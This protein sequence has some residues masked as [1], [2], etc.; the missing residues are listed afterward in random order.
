MLS[1]IILSLVL[2]IV[3]GSVLAPPRNVRI[4][5]GVD[6]LQGDF[7]F[8]VSIHLATRELSS[9]G[10]G[11]ICTGTLISSWAVLTSARCVQNGSGVRVPEEL[12]L[13]VGTKSSTNCSGAV[14]LSVE[15]IRTHEGA[16]LAILRLKWAVTNVE[17]AVLNEYQQDLGKQCIL[18]G[19]GANGTQSG[20]VERL[21]E[22]YVRVVAC[23]DG[24]VCAVSEREHAGAC[25]GD[26]GAPLLCDGS[27]AGILGNDPKECGGQI[28]FKAG[29][30]FIF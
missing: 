14:E 30:Y 19:W 25:H 27:V 7:P 2:R 22:T 3:H 15:D 28:T 23:S 1:F 9:C 17:T 13:L 18:I 24:L 5:G 8:A 29:P 26:L 11:Y 4:V 21:Q 16:N 12:K 20:P 10:S 6:V